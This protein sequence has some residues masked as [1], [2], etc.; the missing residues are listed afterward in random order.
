MC[1][2]LILAFAEGIAHASPVAS[3]SHP[4]LEERRR[5]D[6]DADESEDEPQV[7]LVDVNFNCVS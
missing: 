1:L 7:N 2:L 3:D 4:K 6:P 5:L